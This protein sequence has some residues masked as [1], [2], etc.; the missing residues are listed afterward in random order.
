MLP[1]ETKIP[2]AIA[3][4]FQLGFPTASARISLRYNSAPVCFLVVIL[5]SS[6]W[7][8]SSFLYFSHP[9]RVFIL[10]PLKSVM[11]VGRVQSL[12][13]MAPPPVLLSWSHGF[14]FAVRLLLPSELCPLDSFGLGCRGHETVSKRGGRSPLRTPAAPQN[15]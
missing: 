8:S 11:E 1:D 5:P 6:M 3:F 15:I 4:P 13:K 7:I 14:G 2:F 9:V 12:N 10:R